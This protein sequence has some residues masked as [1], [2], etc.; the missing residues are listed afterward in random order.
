MS[1]AE[2]TRMNTTL[3]EL[4]GAVADGDLDAASEIAASLTG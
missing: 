4:Q 3:E 1:L 2:Q